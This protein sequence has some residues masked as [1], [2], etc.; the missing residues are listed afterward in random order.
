M[1]N[2]NLLSNK[3]PQNR[4]HA[5]QE[6]GQLYFIIHN[7]YF[8]EKSSGFTKSCKSPD[9]GVPI[10]SLV[11][12]ETRLLKQTVSLGCLWGTLSYPGAL[13]DGKAVTIFRVSLLDTGWK[14]NI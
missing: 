14:R 7:I 9:P 4:Q 12:R 6:V 1:S 13:S 8:F 10:Q 2:L 11:N 5:K 3:F